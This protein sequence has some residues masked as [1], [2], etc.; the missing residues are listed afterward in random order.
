MTT[1]RE[2]MAEAAR[3][4]VALAVEGDRLSWRAPAGAVTPDL[5]E[6]MKAHKAAILD[7]LREPD[8]MAR[9][10]YGRPPDCEIPLTVL[11]PML[12]DRDAELLTAFIERQPA[13]VVRWVCCQA[14]RYDVAAPQWQ[15]P[16]V[17]EYAAMLDCLLWQWAELAS[18]P[19]P[20]RASRYDRVQEAVK[21]LRS[22]EEADRYF[23]EHRPAPAGE[24]TKGQQSA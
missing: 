20:D 9:Q 24:K 14:D 18:L 8:I 6:G 23:T 19:A 3:R 15:P 5:I 21:L 16:A 12:S 11:R 17:R 7:A 2:I 13:P 1:A 4:G 22:L 10:R